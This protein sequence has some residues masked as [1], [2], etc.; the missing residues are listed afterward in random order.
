[1]ETLVQKIADRIRNNGPITF[2]EFMKMALYYPELGYY[3]SPETEIGRAG[4]FYTSPHLSPL[5]GAMLGRQAEEMWLHLGRP[6]TFTIVEPG[7][8]RGYMALDMLEH[9]R[10]SEMNEI[11]S[12]IIVELNP[13]L[14]TRQKK[15]LEKFSDKVS[16][17]SSP[18][19]LSPFTGVVFANEILDALPVHM[20]EM[21]EDGLK[22]VFI[23]TE[24]DRLHELLE[25]PSTDALSDYLKEFDA[26]LPHGYRTEINLSVKPWLASYEKKLIEGFMVLVDYGHPAWDY[27]GEDRDRGT[28]LCYHEHQMNENPYKNVG[29]QDI[30]AHVN[31]TSVHEWGASLCLQ[32][33]GYCRQG[34]YLV[35][36]GID[37]LIQKALE[38]SPDSK[39]DVAKA[40]GLIMPGTMGESH[41]VMVLYKGDNAPSL[42]GFTIK[43]ETG[44]LF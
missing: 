41:K 38:N 15:L 24:D 28:L 37:E 11:L 42:R 6:D 36:L 32:P 27:Y 3:T 43:N 44:K 18:D 29:E 7:S 17:V 35:S 5:F 25:E 19:E 16:W 13:S 20:V 30:T 31:F 22:E 8:G 12:Y 2:H 23:D 10:S 39:F 9:L 1:V 21:T 4:D 34:P 40:K 14:K 26:K 33:L